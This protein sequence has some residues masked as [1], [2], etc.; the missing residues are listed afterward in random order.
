MIKNAKVEH[1]R[2]RQSQS[3]GQDELHATFKSQWDGQCRICIRQNFR[4]V[5]KLPHMCI[6]FC[7]VLPWQCFDQIGAIEVVQ[8]LIFYKSSQ[9]PRRNESYFPP[10]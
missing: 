2:L 8:Y 7:I 9:S 3:N 5:K 4:E 6:N 1:H 10:L